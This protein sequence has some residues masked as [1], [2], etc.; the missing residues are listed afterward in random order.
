MEQ[1]ARAP[2]IIYAPGKKSNVAIPRLAEF[3]DLYP[4]LTDLCGLPLPA[5][6]E[7]ISLSPLL[8]DP[9]RSWKKAVFTVVSRP[10]GLGRAVRTETH[11][12]LVWPN[13]SEQLYDHARDPNEYENL[14]ADTR[15]KQTADS[16]RELLSA[17]W[18]AALPK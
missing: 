1:S 5:G 17:G 6:L 2:L 16:L 7:G 9:S 15:L 14:A 3:V 10:G 8:D 13:G 12:L 11:T 18:R 4:T